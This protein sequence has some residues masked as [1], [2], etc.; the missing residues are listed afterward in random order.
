MSNFKND[1]ICFSHLRWTFVFQRPQHLM[2]RF[3]R[4]GRVYFVEEAVIEGGEPRIDVTVCPRTGVSV[5]APFIP[6]T[7]QSGLS[8]VLLRGLMERLLRDQKIHDFVAW[9]Y[10]PMALEF[11]KDLNPTLVVYDCMDELSAFANAPASM[12]HY[13]QLLFKRADLVFTG[14]SSLFEAK[15]T[16]HGQ[17]H[18]FPSSVDVAHFSQALAIREDP[19]DQ[20]TIRRPRIGYAGVIDER[21]DLELIEYLADSRPDWQLVLIGPVV[22]IDPHRLP[23]RTNI[24]YPGMKAYEE[25]PA[26]LSG[27]DV[28]LLPFAQN[29]ATRFISP[30][31]TPEYLAAGLP[32]VSTPIRDVVRPYGESGLV[33]IGGNHEQFLQGVEEQLCKGRSAAW[34]ADVRGFLSSQSWDKTWNSMHRL[35]T[36]HAASK[37]QVAERRRAAA[38]ATVLTPQASAARV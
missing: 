19:A 33:C 32:V 5:V 18:L 30:T 36:S 4:H 6:E 14:G 7:T 23:R 24:H 16:K 25:L 12:L 10:T 28:A 13:E 31:K 26:Y 37:R 8:S 3:A 17:V 27:W 35:M 11:T 20:K 2:S 22:K 34:Q 9:Y 21:M 38:D 1:L 29:D 15:R